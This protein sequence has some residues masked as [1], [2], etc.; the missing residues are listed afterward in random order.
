MSLRVERYAEQHRA[1]WEEFL[2][3]SRNG[4]F[5][6][7]RDYMDCHRDRFADH[8]L[9]ICDNARPV[10][11]L[12]A[13]AE[14]GLLASHGGLTYGGFVTDGRMT[15]PLMLGVFDAVLSFCREQGFAAVRYKAIPYIYHRAPAEEDRYALYLCGAQTEQ[16]RVLT[17]IDLSERLAL[18]ERRRRGIRR[19]QQNGLRACASDDLAGYWRLLSETLRE[20]HDAQPTHTLDEIERL[21]RLF[22]A[23]IR[24][25]ACFEGDA[26][27]AGVLIYASETVARAQYIAASP[28][29]RETGALDL[30][31]DH[32][33]N[34]VYAG[35]RYFD[36]GTSHEPLTQKL[37]AGLIAQKEGFGGRAVVQDT[38]WID[39]ERWNPA[40]L[41][42]ALT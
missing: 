21:A 9:V 38:Y 25:Y 23:N 26:M 39:L 15:T 11:L 41:R 13:N 22:P 17:V 2:A 31:F 16:R 28:R 24:L 5:L 7:R 12:P 3:R 34:E 18:Q 30:L 6:F 4:T 27:L 32:L 14:G 19:A 42:E 1:L 29:G 35:K 8:S 33:I 40:A 10:A 37:N 20:R 36:F